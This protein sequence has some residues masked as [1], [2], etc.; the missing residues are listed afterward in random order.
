MVLHVVIFYYG[1]GF[2]RCDSVFSLAFPFPDS[3]GVMQFS[4]LG[5]LDCQMDLKLSEVDL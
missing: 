5:E 4:C 1:M 2:S 3:D